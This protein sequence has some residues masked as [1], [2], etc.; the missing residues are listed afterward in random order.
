MDLSIA[1]LMAILIL[2]TDAV[3][4][5]GGGDALC[6]IL[7]TGGERKT[8]LEKKSISENALRF[9]SLVIDIS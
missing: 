6:G 9:S 3:R 4:G 5:K 2:A 1:D 7:E 8:E